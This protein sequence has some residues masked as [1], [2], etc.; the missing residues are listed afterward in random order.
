M[1][2]IDTL[3][4]ETDPNVYC[5]TLVLQ[6]D[7]TL[8]GAALA[9]AIAECIEANGGTITGAQITE[10]AQTECE[11]GLLQMKIQMSRYGKYHL[12]AQTESW[13]IPITYPAVINSQSLYFEVQDINGD[14]YRYINNSFENISTQAIRLRRCLLTIWNPCYRMGV[15]SC[16]GPKIMPKYATVK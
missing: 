9:A 16:R 7:P 14:I 12:A 8:T 13:T 1:I 11:A 6:D 2:N 3:Y 15:R 10:N 4:C 5:E